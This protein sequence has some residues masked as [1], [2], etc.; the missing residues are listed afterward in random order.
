MTWHENNLCSW[1]EWES[2][3]EAARQRELFNILKR[4]DA[5]TAN[6]SNVIR[7]YAFGGGFLGGSVTVLSFI[8]VKLFLF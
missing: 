6:I 3:D 4:L 7:Y 1:E 5:R 2:L 8:G